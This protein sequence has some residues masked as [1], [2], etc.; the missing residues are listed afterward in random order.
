MTFFFFY[1]KFNL[2][3]TQYICGGFYV[4]HEKNSSQHDNFSKYRL[5][6]TGM[7]CL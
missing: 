3:I 1:N 6:I 2:I 7:T 5:R 4:Q